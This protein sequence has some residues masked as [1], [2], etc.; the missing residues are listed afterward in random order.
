MDTWRHLLSWGVYSY[1]S[2]L[3]RFEHDIALHLT[4]SN[5]LHH[6]K[7]C[8]NHS[9]KPHYGH[10]TSQGMEDQHS[11]HSTSQ[12]QYHKDGQYDT[13]DYMAKHN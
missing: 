9:I 1:D 7:P 4:D 2:I 5:R 11:Q 3:S 8:S 6:S 10:I 12:P 13:Q